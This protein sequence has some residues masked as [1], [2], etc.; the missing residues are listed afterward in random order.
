[1]GELGRDGEGV[2]VLWEAPNVEKECSDKVS[3]FWKA[4]SSAT[5]SA[6]GRDAAAAS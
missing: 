3:L 4:S 5:Y 6:T 1:M 2:E